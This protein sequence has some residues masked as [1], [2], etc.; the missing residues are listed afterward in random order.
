MKNMCNIYIIKYYYFVKTID[1]MILKFFD[2]LSTKFSKYNKTFMMFMIKL[3]H[4]S[5]LIHIDAFKPQCPK[6]QELKKIVNK[7][8]LRHLNLNFF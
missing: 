3:K 7:K 4:D 6:S 1:K 8:F 5:L 2:D